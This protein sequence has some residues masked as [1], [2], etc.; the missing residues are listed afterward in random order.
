MSKR[1]EE[2]KK[3]IAKLP[4][5]P[6]HAGTRQRLAGLLGALPEQSLGNSDREAIAARLIALLQPRVLRLAQAPVPRARMINLSRIAPRTYVLV[7]ALCV[8]LLLW[9]TRTPT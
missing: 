2:T 4:G 9:L 3:G 5:T 8:F 6:T 7:F 1:L